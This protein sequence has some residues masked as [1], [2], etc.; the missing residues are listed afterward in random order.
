MRGARRALLRV[1]IAAMA[2]KNRTHAAF[3]ANSKTPP[4]LS[5][6][7]SVIDA[8]SE[9]RIAEAGSPSAAEAKEL[10]ANAAN[11]VAVMVR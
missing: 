8:P 2:A 7:K 11:V 6:P 10:S 9:P 5:K 4:L 1:A 3:R